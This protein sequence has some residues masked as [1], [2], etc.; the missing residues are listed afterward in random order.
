MENNKMVKMS[1]VL[2][3]LTNIFQKVSIVLCGVCVIALI[4]M[5]TKK[6]WIPARILDVDIG[7]LSLELAGKESIVGDFP[8]KYWILV[9]IVA[10]GFL[11]LI[12]YGLQ[13]IRNILKPM[14]QGLP[15]DIKVSDN[16][17]KLGCVVIV[18]GIINAVF[19]L[20][21]KKI[22]IGAY[23]FSKILNM[24][25]VSDYKVHFSLDFSFI[26][27]ALVIFLLAYIFRYG[28]ELQRESDE[29]L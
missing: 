26:I 22:L 10:I 29:T 6:D 17:R 5:G 27:F 13:I 25:A 23:D 2:D 24:Q 1:K 7:D 14:K 9:G 12:C 28:E 11:I 21:A 18:G 3:V 15:F 4:L 16:L 19:E 8:T 20:V